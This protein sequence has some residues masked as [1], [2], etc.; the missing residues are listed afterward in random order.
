MCM[1]ESDGDP[2]PGQKAA[3]PFSFPQEH[4]V[5]DGQL[6]LGAL[7]IF[8]G[9]S[10][11]FAWWSRMSAFFAP[12]TSLCSYK[13]STPCGPLGPLWCLA[14]AFYRCCVTAGAIG[15]KKGGVSVSLYVVTDHRLSSSSYLQDVHL[16]HTMR[17]GRESVTRPD[18]E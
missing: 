9:C 5:R 11:G 10:F 3:Y 12:E 18:F 14:P 15:E 13:N 4:W 8:L 1:S 2:R 16:V 7:G 17:D 6:V